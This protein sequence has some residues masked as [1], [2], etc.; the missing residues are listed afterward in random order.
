MSKLLSKKSL[1]LCIAIALALIIAGAFIV[2]F[3]GYNADSTQRDATVVEI[4]DFAYSSHD[5][6]VQKNLADF[7]R[8]EIGSKYTV[9]DYTL[10]EGQT[11]GAV[12]QFVVKGTPDAAFCEQLKSAIVGENMAGV[13]SELVTVSSHVLEN[14]PYYNYIWR[15][16]VAAAVVA[17]ILFV[18]VAIR[19]RLGM[20]VAVLIAAVHDVLVMLALV[21]IVRL[22]A[23]V[24]LAGVAVFGLLLSAVVNMFVFGRMRRDFRTEEFKDKAAREAVAQSLSASKGLVLGLS[25]ALI[26]VAVV[27]GV[28]GAVIGT[29][30]TFFMI[31]ALISVLLSA[32]SSLLLAPSLYAV[33][34]EKSDAARAEKTKYNYSSDKKKDKSA[35]AV[36]PA[37]ETL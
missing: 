36:E 31:A 17:V 15:T 23:G 33:I 14:A 18:Y 22:P 7:C 37:G 16:A 6:T 28:I 3:V 35:K 20:G 19:F 29:D 24:S 5:E 32:Y 2:G 4:S 8:S 11:G 27:L 21:A 9:T 34:K 10:L 25:V 30:L 1:F 12:L 13:S 26:V